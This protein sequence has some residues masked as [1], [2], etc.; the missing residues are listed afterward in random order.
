MEEMRKCSKKT[1]SEGSYS[2]NAC[3]GGSKGGNKQIERTKQERKQVEKMNASKNS[4]NQASKLQECFQRGKQTH[5]LA[6]CWKQVCK[7][8]MKHQTATINA[9]VKATKKESKLLASIPG[10]K[11]QTKEAGIAQFRKKKKEESQRTNCKSNSNENDRKQ[12]T[13]LCEGLKIR[14]PESKHANCTNADIW[15]RKKPTNQTAQ[16]IASKDTRKQAR[17]QQ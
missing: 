3:Y 1:C 16:L 17:H 8:V 2:I 4:R 10:R 6:K 14:E 13:N 7:K 9:N 5:T 15:R 12:A 11:R